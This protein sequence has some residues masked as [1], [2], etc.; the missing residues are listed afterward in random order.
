MSTDK[1]SRSKTLQERIIS[2]LDGSTPSKYIKVVA[3][4]NAAG[5]VSYKLTQVVISGHKAL[6][7]EGE[8][9]NHEFTYYPSL[10]LAGVPSHVAHFATTSKISSDY[11]RV[12]LSKATHLS[13]DRVSYPEPSVLETAQVGGVSKSVVWNEVTVSYADLFVMQNSADP[14]SSPTDKHLSSLEDISREM[15]SF[16]GDSDIA[17]AKAE[18]KSGFSVK[19]APSRDAA[20]LRQL[21]GEGSAAKPL[22]VTSYNKGKFTGTR[23]TNGMGA[24]VPLSTEEGNALSHVYF[25]PDVRN[26]LKTAPDSVTDFLVDLGYSATEARRIVEAAMRSSLSPAAKTAQTS[27]A[28]PPLVSAAPV[29]A[30]WAP[31]VP[32]APVWGSVPAPLAGT[33]WGTA[34]SGT[35]TS[36]PGLTPAT[37]TNPF[38]VLSRSTASSPRSSASGGVFGTATTVP[39]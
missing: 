12:G 17:P 37:A 28:A 8:R 20:Y 29:A 23:R 33:P 13:A 3:S 27:F 11:F 9:K 1:K 5:A 14:S 35:A 39:R 24:G 26:G 36:M 4:V 22:N 18:P 34:A 32:A 2:V 31:P 16:L 38:P 30:P 25:K 21:V 10:R 7:G 6:W 19:K 15:S